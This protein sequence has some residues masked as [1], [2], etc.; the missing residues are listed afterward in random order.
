M[1]QMSS[2]GELSEQT[3]KLIPAS[4]ALG[5]T[6]A[7]TISIFA[8][9]DAFLSRENIRNSEKNGGLVGTKG[10]SGSR[11]LSRFGQSARYEFPGT[12]HRICGTSG[13]G[14][15]DGIRSHHGWHWYFLAIGGANPRIFSASNLLSGYIG[16]APLHF[17]GLC[18]TGF[19]VYVWRRAHRTRQGSDQRSEV[20]DVSPSDSQSQDTCCYI[21][22]HGSHSWLRLHWLLLQHWEGYPVLIPCIISSIVCNYLCGIESATNAP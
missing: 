4:V 21:C 20:C 6:L 17:F 9:R 10:R 14:H 18:N 16:N 5:G 13:N 11:D 2:G 7:L 15:C 22:H 1:H 19:S 3:N 8:F 12:G